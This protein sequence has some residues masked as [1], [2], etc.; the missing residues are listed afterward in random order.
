MVN[1]QLAIMGQIDVKEDEE[2]VQRYPM[3]LLIKFKTVEE[4]RQAIA[5]GECKFTF[6]DE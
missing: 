4:I 6:G 2:T 3:A 1:G 5:D